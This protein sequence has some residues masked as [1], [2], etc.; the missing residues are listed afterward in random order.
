MTASKSSG[1]PIR[2][3]AWVLAAWLLA[4]KAPAA[5]TITLDDV[6]NDGAAG[7]LDDVG[8]DVENITTGS[9][10]DYRARG[11]NNVCTYRYLLDGSVTREFTY[12]STNGMMVVTNP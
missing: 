8:S 1:S 6:A 7:E 11:R 12:D 4:L 10:A 2:P 9:G 5:I 3:A